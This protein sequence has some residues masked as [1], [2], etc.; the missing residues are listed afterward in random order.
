MPSASEI[1][2]AFSEAANSSTSREG[3]PSLPH[4][5]SE[6]PLAIRSSP[7][8]PLFARARLPLRASRFAAR[9]FALREAVTDLPGR[10]GIESAVVEGT[11]GNG[12]EE[13]SMSTGIVD[14]SASEEGRAVVAGVEE[15]TEG[16]G[17]ATFKEVELL[18]FGGM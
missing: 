9:L 4:S 13:V 1:S 2:F 8:A 16:E 14:G 10:R 12:G 18:A 6:S 17:L 5:T 3:G 11:A 15:G 7:A